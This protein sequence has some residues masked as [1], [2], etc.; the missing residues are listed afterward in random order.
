MNKIKKHQ[1]LR[2]NSVFFNGKRRIAHNV[3]RVTHN[4]ILNLVSSVLRYALR[5]MC[6]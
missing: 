1:R 3:E 4:E 6:F 2:L 5:V